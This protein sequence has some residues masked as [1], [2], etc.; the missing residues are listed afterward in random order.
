MGEP[1]PISREP[2]SGFLGITVCTLADSNRLRLEHDSG[3]HRYVTINP[4]WDEGYRRDKIEKA[5][6][7]LQ[8]DAG[9]VR[10]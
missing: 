3:Q 5:A 2:L 10:R 4:D 7:Q 1:I 9:R 6:R 8:R